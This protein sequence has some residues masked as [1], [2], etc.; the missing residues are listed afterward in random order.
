METL[1][2]AAIL[3][4]DDLKKELLTIPEWGGDVYIR[5]MTGIERDK[6]EEWAINSGK[7]L[8]GIRGRIASLCLVDENGVR[9]FTDEDV[10]ALGQ[11]SAAALERIV[12]AVMKLN[13]VTTADIK[14]IA[15]N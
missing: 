15:G 14:E 9:L 1:T 6:Y 10:D 12:T 2:K 5:V 11:K 13:G 3:A 4:F 7:S 8:Q